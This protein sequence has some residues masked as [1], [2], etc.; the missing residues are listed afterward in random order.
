M[1]LNT[2]SLPWVGK[3]NK[4]THICTALGRERER[5][6]TCILDLGVCVCVS[7]TMIRSGMAI[8]DLL[9]ASC[10]GIWA[11]PFWQSKQ[12]NKQKCSLSPS[13][14]LSFPSFTYW[15]AGSL[16]LCPRHPQK[17]IG[18]CSQKVPFP[19]ICI[20]NAKNKKKHFIT[21]IFTPKT[22]EF[23]NFG[24]SKFLDCKSG[25]WSKKR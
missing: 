24:I 17:K 9:L 14:M 16:L 12:S 11:L 3:A 21:L 23:V 5:Y 10:L 15:V 4:Q 13:K 7:P 20:W 22:K 8:A 19:N 6:C 25:I 18:I 2:I 1:N